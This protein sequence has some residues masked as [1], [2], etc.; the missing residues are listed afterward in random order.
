MKNTKDKTSD[1]RKKCK[2]SPVFIGA[3]MPHGD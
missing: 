3:K 2:L 1:S